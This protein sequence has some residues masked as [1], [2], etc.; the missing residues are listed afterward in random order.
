MYVAFAWHDLV[1]GYPS[2]LCGYS[3]SI[4]ISNQICIDE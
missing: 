3:W 4:G 1:L 2:F